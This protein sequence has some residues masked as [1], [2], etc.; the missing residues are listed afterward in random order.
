MPPVLQT[1]LTTQADLYGNIVGQSVV[2]DELFF[3]LSTRIKT[4]LA[5]QKQIYQLLGCLD[6]LISA[7][8]AKS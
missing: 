5:F 4:E 3:K 8:A 6:M 2:L 1:L 7:S